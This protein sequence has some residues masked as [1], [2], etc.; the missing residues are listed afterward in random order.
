MVL[1]VGGAAQ[2]KRELARA[3][4][5]C[6][7][8]LLGDTCSEQDLEGAVR[9]LEAQR[10]VWRQLA[11]ELPLSLERLEEL[12]AKAEVVTYS[13]EGSGVIPMERFQRAYRE[14]A[15]RFSCRLA[16]RAQ[17]VYQVTCGISRQIK[18]EEHG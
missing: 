15:G 14:E 13:L 2:G 18:G 4:D 7:P 10:L 9:I 8:E 5:P 1:I 3:L 17:E 11:G 12:L 6:A 16:D